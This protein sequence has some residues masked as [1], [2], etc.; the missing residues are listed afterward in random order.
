MRLNPLQPGVAFLYPLKTSENRGYRK[1]TPVCNGLNTILKYQMTPECRYSYFYKFEYVLGGSVCVR[2]CL[3]KYRL[4]LL[5]H[6][7][8]KT[9]RNCSFCFRRR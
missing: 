5:I 4:A 9:M 6:Y 2:M 8:Y 1:A 7:S 3:D